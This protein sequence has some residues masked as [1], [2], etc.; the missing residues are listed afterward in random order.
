[1]LVLI[2]VGIGTGYPSHPLEVKKAL[3]NNTLVNLEN[4]GTNGANVL[5]ISSNSTGTTDI[6]D[7]QNGAFIV[8]GD[9]RIGI[10][11]D[12]PSKG[13]LEISGGGATQSMSNFGYL[14]HTA[15]TGIAGGPY[16][17]QYSLYA[18]NKIAAT[19]FNAFSDQRIKNINGISDS[20]EDLTTL[21]QIEITD[22]TLIDTIEKGSQPYKK[23]IAQQLAQVYPQ[24][25]TTNLTETIPDIYQRAKVQDGWIE[26]AT[27]LQAG[28]KVKIITENSTADYEV[29][30]V[31]ATRFKVSGLATDISK[32]FVYGREV[33]DF[34]TVD[35][36]AIAM[37]NVS[38]TQQQQ[39]I[40]DQQ[41]QKIETLEAQLQELMAFKVEFE[42]ALKMTADSN[43]T[44]S[45]NN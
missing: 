45:N 35:Y 41:Q 25:V 44:N 9:G 33:S 32:V 28:E 37:L 42:N 27:N 1:M 21:M 31:K 30:E 20:K 4:E 11:T 22:Y 19:E 10:G 12:N 8:Q 7:I 34:H 23:V 43:K 2:N 29:L 5:S 17:Y 36:E 14:N 13:K 16:N 26:L 6:V 24:A 38:A 40:I 18:D 15:P 3:N 39:Q